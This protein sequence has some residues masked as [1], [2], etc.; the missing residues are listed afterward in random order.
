MSRFVSTGAAQFDTLQNQLLER[1][2]DDADDGAGGRAAPAPTDAHGPADEGVTATDADP[3]SAP[4]QAADP[5]AEPAEDAAERPPSVHVAPGEPPGETTGLT[6]TAGKGAATEA[7]SAR[8]PGEAPR[9]L[10]T[11]DGVFMPVTLNVLGI[12]LFLR[13]GFILGQA[14][15]FGALL[16]LTLSYAI[17]L[18]TVLSLN[19]ISTNGQVR[20][21]GAYYLI[22][23]SLGP[24]FGGSIGLVF[25]FG[26]AFNASMNVLGFVESLMGALGERSGEL[27]VLPEGSWYLLLYGTAVLWLSMVVCMFGARIFTRATLVLAVVMGIAVGSMLL[28][29]LFMTPFEDA[30]REVYYTSFSWSTLAENAWPHFTAGAEG[31]V[32]AG[33]EN[34]Q[35]VFGVLFPAVC[36]VL[37][38]AS[39]SGDLRKPSKS[40]PKGT[41]WALAFTFGVYVIVFV[42]LAATVARESFYRNLGIVGEVSLWP[43]LIVLGEL[44]SCGFSALMG[45]MA[46]A[47]MLQ[48]IARDELLPALSPFAQGLGH[49]D[50][51]ALAL[52]A[53][54]IVCQLVLF[55]DSINTIAQL[56]TMTTLLTFGTLSLATFALKAGG[57]PSF[58]PSFRYFNIW[59]AGGGA[60]ACFAAMLITDA[61]TACA[62]VAVTALLFVTIQVYTLPKPWGD[63]SHNVTYH[64]VRK[65]LLRL[66][67]RKG[68]VKYWRPQIL[69]LANNPRT[70]WN[71]IIFCNSLKKGALYLLGHVIKGDFHECLPELRRQHSAWLTL[72]D[73]SGVKSFVDVVIARDEREGARNLILTSG[74]GGMRPNII[75]LGFPAELQRPSGAARG[76]VGR[77]RSIALQVSSLPTDSA[78]RE[79]PIRSQ[80]YVGILE[81]TLALNRALAI[82]FGF[83]AMSLPGPSS[84]AH[85]ARPQAAQYI[86][87]WPV[88]IASPGQSE[89]HIWD[90]YT[91]VLQL[92]TILSFTGTWKAHHLRVNVFVE[93]A[94]ETDAE[95][96]RVR[97]L[98][99]NLRIPASL[100][101]F[102]LSNGSVPRYD[103]IVLGKRALDREVGEALL[104]DPWW[105][106]VCEMR[107]EQ[108]SSAAQGRSMP[109]ELG[110]RRAERAARRSS[111]QSQ[112]N[113]GVSLPEEHLAY[114]RNN[115]RLGLAHPRS[116]HAPD[117]E[118]DVASDEEDELAYDELESQL[119]S[120]AIDWDPVYARKLG[121][122]GSRGSRTPR[123]DVATPTARSFAP[124]ETPT[125]NAAQ[126]AS[127]G[128]LSSSERTLTPSMVGARRPTSPGGEGRSITPRRSPRLD[129]LS[130]FPGERRGARS[131]SETPRADSPGSSSERSSPVPPVVHPLTFNV[132]PNKAQY[133]ILNELIRR[134]SSQ[135]TSVVLTALPAPE[136]GASASKEASD[137]YLAQLQSLYGGGPPVLGVHAKTLTMTMSL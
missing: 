99:D 12:I 9:K 23:R 112:R 15:L 81:D 18:L 19:A 69:L 117:D 101:V 108:E 11:W 13:F 120:L 65:Y 31:S 53:T 28:S 40:I 115:I 111:K 32:R 52:L 133:L 17:D 84:V 55:I 77:P 72:V 98:L 122:G 34:W 63:V 24:E 119:A 118:S 96:T 124:G 64:F 35:S 66:D 37:A 89:A 93:H 45:V 22:S 128:A 88:Q 132:L 75:V 5:H 130:P 68:H 38:G 135:A 126:P 29:A 100:R 27:S 79:S 61:Y 47:Q 121:G 36:G 50:V 85:Y 59:T 104:G 16:L 74:L 58:R 20:G 82:A 102:C 1:G 136:P 125:A 4:A 114:H 51:P 10:G 41:N 105:I 70:D 134:N 42:L 116:R 21:G 56:V 129:T 2:P 94:E 30:R 48:A 123:S 73:V 3:A 83:D 26:Q 33:R 39:M 110:A 76:P 137:R 97:T 87:L 25:F 103:A 67:E 71:L 78:R 80:T 95:R 106:R 113:L 62:C 46:C 127:Y 54:T 86:D 91:M 8:A 44:A 109:I 7:R 131:G 49:G 90:T 43:A 60:L 92:G 57:A 6:D 14:G 107:R